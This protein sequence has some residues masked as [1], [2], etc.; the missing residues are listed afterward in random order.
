VH[1]IVAN[2][3]WQAG[4]EVYCVDDADAKDVLTGA[5]SASPKNLLVSTL[6]DEIERATGGRSISLSLA[7]K[8]RAATL[9]AG[10]SG[11]TVLWLNGGRLSWTTSTFYAKDGKLPDWVVK[12]NEA[13]IP[14]LKEGFRWERSL[15]ESAYVRAQPTLAPGAPESFGASFPHSVRTYADWRMT[16]DANEFTLSTAQAGIRALGMGKDEVPDLLAVSLSANDYLGHAFGPDSP[17]VLEMCV[18]TDRAIRDFLR[19]LNRE[20]PG[21]LASVAIAFTADHGVCNTPED[22]AARGL[23]MRRVSPRALQQFVEDGLQAAFGRK[24]FIAYFDEASVYLNSKA[25]ND[26]GVDSRRV[27]IFIR[28]R[29][30]EYPDVL[31]AYY[32]PEIHL[33]DEGPVTHRVR[34]SYRKGRSPEVYYI[35]PPGFYPGAFAGGTGHGSPWSYDSRVPVIFAGPW[36]AKGRFL[37]ACSPE[38]VVPTLCEVAGAARPTG[39]AGRAVGLLAR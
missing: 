18:R 39:A 25:M 32:L 27:G 35:L 6:T 3:W 31:T 5:A 1:G 36:F 19:F 21:G 28:D 12:I 8:D 10:R 14:R 2:S 22:E 29:L 20:I 17:E 7:L 16:P 26:A 4:A 11:D 30:L 38:D 33:S 9:M 23:P 37:D 34:R 15:P 13:G 24:D